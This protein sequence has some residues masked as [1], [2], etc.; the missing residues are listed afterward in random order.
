MI[1]LVVMMT[2]TMLMTTPM[3][4]PQLSRQ[5]I[6]TDLTDASQEDIDGGVT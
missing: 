3:T 1:T 5:V 2:M 4:T 6:D